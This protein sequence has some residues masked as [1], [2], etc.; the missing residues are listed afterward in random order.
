MNELRMKYHRDTGIR[1]QDYYSAT[2]DERVI[3]A[4]V[5]WLE[6]QLSDCETVHEINNSINGKNTEGT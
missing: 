4:Y 3:E 1:I 2:D 6:E 5:E